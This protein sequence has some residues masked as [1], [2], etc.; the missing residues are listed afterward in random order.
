LRAVIVCIAIAAS[1]LGCAAVEKAPINAAS[2]I[3]QGVRFYFSHATPDEIP[4]VT[5][6]T[7]AT[8]EKAIE[9]A[10]LSAVQEAIGVFVVSEVTVA[11]DRVV[12]DIAANYSSGV[13][14]EY[15]VIEC[16]Q[17]QFIEC[18]INAKVSAFM[19]QR[20]LLSSASVTKIDGENLYA[21][22]LT[23]RVAIQQ[24]YRLT[25]YFLSK[26][27]TE[28]LRVKLNRFEI[29]P[30][31]KSK[32]PVFIEYEIQFD[33]DYFRSLVKFLKI[34]ESDTGGGNENKLT[35]RHRGSPNIDPHTYYIQWAAT[36]LLENRVWIHTYDRAFHDMIK[37]YEFSDITLKFRELDIC[38]KVTH[39]GIF[40]I[41]W[42]GLK[43]TALIEIEPHKL[44]NLQQLSLELGC[45]NS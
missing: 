36:G 12:S 22:Y 7:G 28:G 38:E 1:L 4:V 27:R 19:F 23:S 5:R 3:V 39:I 29:Q 45:V 44:K 18:Q 13:V 2:L 30:S 6:G 34:L 10:L 25:E 14:K 8:R 31:S 26:V 11:S 35:G 17:S 20:N 21:Q 37:H 9:N 40:S 41:N 42:Y 15:K 43:R 32:V 24:R 33:K 16:K